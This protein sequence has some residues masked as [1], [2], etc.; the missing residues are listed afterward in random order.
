MFTDIEFQTDYDGSLTE[1]NDKQRKK[2]T[3]KQMGLLDDFNLKDI[4]GRGTSIAIIDMIGKRGTKGFHTLHEAFRGKI[5]SGDIKCFKRKNYEDTAN[6]ATVCAGIAVGQPFKGYCIKSGKTV[7]INYKG[8]VAP[9]AKAKI[10]LIEKNYGFLEALSEI[11][12]ENFDV[13][14]ISLGSE[15][16]N[17]RSDITKKL[18]DLSKSALVVVSAGNNGTVEDVL[19]PA[20]LDEV[21]SVGSYT[22]FGKEAQ[23]SPDDADICCYGDVNAPA[24]DDKHGLL[25]WATGTSMAAPAIAGLICLFIQCA[26]EGKYSP[27]DSKEDVIQQ[28][29]Q[30]KYMMDILNETLVKK[31]KVKPAKL[32]DE[33]LR[34]ENFKRWFDDTIK[35]INH[36]N[37]WFIFLGLCCTYSV[38]IS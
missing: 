30:K 1:M 15:I 34:T 14:S 20:N 6:H 26:K 37:N 13:V 27:Q 3:V 4:K 22:E 23:Y 16:S 25:Q 17:A 7:S 10:F 31:K 21:I 2:F 9:E 36:D 18:Q 24:S 11:Q 35:G 5:F 12:K 32:L 19:Y 33:A 29:K 28:M 8:G 38:V